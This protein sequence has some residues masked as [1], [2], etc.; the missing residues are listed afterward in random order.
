MSKG[1]SYPSDTQPPKS[2]GAPSDVEETPRVSIAIVPRFFV[3]LARFCWDPRDHI[4]KL[5]DS[6]EKP[7]YTPWMAFTAGVAI[8]LS[9]LA[10][11]AATAIRHFDRVVLFATFLVAFTLAAIG[12]HLIAWGAGGR[13]RW[14]HT[15]ATVEYLIG[16]VLPPIAVLAYITVYLVNLADGVSCSL[17]DFRSLGTTVPTAFNKTLHSIYLA[18]LLGSGVAFAWLAVRCIAQVHR[19]NSV[20]AAI[21][22]LAPTIAVFFCWSYV[23]FMAKLWSGSIH[24]IWAIVTGR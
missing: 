8:C 15:I 4:E 2:E 12:V 17:G 1:F 5:V 24:T 14:V 7:R 10:V 20:R 19:F 11:D 3:E 9:V 23:S 16:F 6:T 18:V 13:G 22:V 21:A